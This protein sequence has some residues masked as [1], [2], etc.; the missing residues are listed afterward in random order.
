MSSSLQLKG[1]P[2]VGCA[3]LKGVD[4]PSGA[5]ALLIR[6]GV[7]FSADGTRLISY[8][9]DRKQYAVPDGVEVI[10]AGAFS[11]NEKLMIVSFPESLK[12]IEDDAFLDCSMLYQLDFSTGLEEI[13]NRA[14]SNCK[15]L[16]RLILPNGLRRIGERC[17]AWDF[18]LNITLPEGME[19]IGDDAFKGC[20]QVNHTSAP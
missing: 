1:N 4:F 20:Y 7:I 10:G 19:E 18:E 13:G 16:K 11:N 8:L 17:F 2:F 15:E 6:D 5:D 3:S 12:T 14:F 9:G